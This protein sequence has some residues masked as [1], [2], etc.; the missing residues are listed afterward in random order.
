M[1]PLGSVLLPG[2]LLPLH[3]FEPRYRQLVADLLADDVNEPEFG[4][5]MIE[6]GQETGGGEDRADVGV[7]GRVVQIEAL[8]DGRYG[9]VVVGTSRFRV[10]S[11]L[12]D[13]PY[14]LADIDEWPDEEPDD[15][16][17]PDLVAAARARIRDVHRRAAELGIEQAPAGGPEERASDAPK[18]E[19]GEPEISDDPL[20]ATYHLAG[21]APL[22]AADRYRLLCA[23]SPRRRLALLDEALDDVVAMIEFRRT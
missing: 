16:R 18:P 5:T 13:D 22:G 11:W 12:P 23:E 21:I 6:R 15:P 17:I 14:P 19:I 9:L 3:I 4:V 20:L 8:P 7:I 1:F 10:R 2:G